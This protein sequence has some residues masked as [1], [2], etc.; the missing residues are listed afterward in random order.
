MSDLPQTRLPEQ[1]CPVCSHKLDSHTLLFEAHVAPS[2]GDFSVCIQCATILSFGPDLSLAP[3]GDL[4][5]LD[6]DDDTKFQLRRVQ[7]QIQQRARSRA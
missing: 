5:S 4:Y 2:P 1:A 6:V 3:I 7:Q